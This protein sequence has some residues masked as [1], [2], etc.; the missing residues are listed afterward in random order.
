MAKGEELMT[1]PHHSKCT[2]I[3]R[4]VAVM[5]A[6]L[7]MCLLGSMKTSIMERLAT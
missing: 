4:V 1:V 7:M 5:L 3:G 6:F 2:Y